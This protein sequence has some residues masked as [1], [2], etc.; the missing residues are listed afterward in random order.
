MQHKGNIIF[1]TSFQIFTFFSTILSTGAKTQEVGK[2]P[3]LLWLEI[4]FEILVAQLASGE[5]AIQR[6]G[7]E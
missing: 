2:F 3:G 6:S 7:E 5:D 4:C 1:S